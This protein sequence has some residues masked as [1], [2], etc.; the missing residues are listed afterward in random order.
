MQSVRTGDLF[1]HSQVYMTTQ[2]PFFEPD[3]PDPI[4]LMP[5]EP[6]GE[7]FC[8]SSGRFD[9]SVRV[10][11]TSF[12]PGLF[13]G[14]AAQQVS[15]RV[16][17]AE[18]HI[19]GMGRLYPFATCAFQRIHIVTSANRLAKLHVHMRQT[20]VTYQYSFSACTC[21]RDHETGS[22]LCSKQPCHAMQAY[23]VSIHLSHIGVS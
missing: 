13:S 3:S 17:S 9:R 5:E 4:L 7:S 11:T 6:R 12:M 20:D 1:G 23:L 8:R 16:L 14:C 22:C 10:L 18:G 2:Q 19:E 15:M 21:F